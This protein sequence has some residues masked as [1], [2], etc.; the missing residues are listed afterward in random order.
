MSSACFNHKSASVPCVLFPQNQ[1][2][3]LPTF[4]PCGRGI[5]LENLPRLLSF[6]THPFSSLSCDH[7]VSPVTTRWLF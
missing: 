4:A 1:G 5:V 3:N 2:S 7:L 6:T